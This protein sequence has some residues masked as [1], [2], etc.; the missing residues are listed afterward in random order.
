MARCRL[1][2]AAPMAISLLP[3]VWRIIGG[4]AMRR[5]SRIIGIVASIAVGCLAGPG[6]L[7]AAA[8]RPAASWH[9]AYRAP[10]HRQIWGITA[11]ALTDGWAFGY[12][13]GTQNALVRTF[14]LHWGGHRWRTVTIPV[15]QNFVAT[16]IK[17][18]SPSN[19]WIFG[20]RTDSAASGAALVYNGHRWKV[21]DGPWS[22]SVGNGLVASR[23]DAWVTQGG[24]ATADCTTT[25]HHWDGSA[26]QSQAVPGQL[27]LA[28][29]G[30][31]PWLVG[32]AASAKPRLGADVPAVYRW[33]GTRWR[34]LRAPAG[35]AD[36]AFGAAS[37]GARL[38]LVV[39]GRA[40]GKWRLFERRGSTWSSLGV[41]R[42]FP[43]ADVPV[44]GLVYD[45]RNG[46]WA[47]PFHWTGSRWV[48]TAPG[49]RLNPPRPRWLNTL[50][51]NFMA[52]VPGSSAV[53]AVVLANRL[54]YTSGT[55][56]SG[57]AWYG[58]KP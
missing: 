28:G 5:G 41:L 14:Y 25:V 34:H 42:R 26:W 30:S 35:A 50:W 7:A 58:A 48:N 37:P 13:Y 27:S 18:S 49:M 20:Y 55:T 9:L 38:W 54:P 57:I 6:A 3:S 23:S 29:G 47:L 43:A 44:P 2:L 32:L 1:L 17:A 39:Q 45:G 24:C 16:L 56:Q 46:F 4:F 21:I 10:S 12:V 19:V 11:P 22:A 51:Y 33:S 53:W 8:H 40:G 31:R 15:A 36:E 52:P